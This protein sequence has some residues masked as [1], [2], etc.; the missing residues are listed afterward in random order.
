MAKTLKSA[1]KV[2]CVNALSLATNSFLVDLQ[3]KG[4]ALKGAT[5][6][7]KLQKF[8][9]FYNNLIGASI[10]A[11]II[12]EQLSDTLIQSCTIWASRPGAAPAAVTEFESSKAVAG[13]IKSS[14]FT[15]IPVELSDDLHENFTD[16]TKAGFLKALK[17]FCGTKDGYIT[18]I[19]NAINEYQTED[20]VEIFTN[21]G[22]GI[23]NFCNAIVDAFDENKKNMAQFDLNLDELQ[24]SV[25]KSTSAVAD[26]GVVASKKTASGE[27]GL[28]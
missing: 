9:T 11:N 5:E 24:G 27:D 22:I 1:Q 14:M 26:V 20:T 17:D 25:R 23:E 4:N 21:I 10:A 19:A 12:A 16:D 6:E 15:A 7:I 18:A 8:D 28:N 13:S 3:A 2:A